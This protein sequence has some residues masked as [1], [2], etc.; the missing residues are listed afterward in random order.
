V[1]QVNFPDVFTSEISTPYADLLSVNGIAS[2]ADTSLA[3][4]NPTQAV[5]PT[6]EIRNTK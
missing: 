3:S 4:F 1:L 6:V 5:K 2:P